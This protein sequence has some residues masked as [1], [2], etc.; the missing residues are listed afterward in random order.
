AGF[1][2]DWGKSADTFTVQGDA[3]QNGIDQPLGRED[4]T[5]EGA[6]L[7][8][9]WGRA[10]SKGSDL[11]VQVYLDHT[12]RDY[13]ASYRERRNT[14]D[15][16]VQHHF[17]IGGRNEIVWGGGYRNS[18]DEA[19]GLTPVIAFIPDTKDLRLINIFAQDQIALLADKLDL[20]LGTK[21]EHNDYT[22]WE[23]EPSARLA[24][25]PGMGQMLWAAVSRATRTPSRVD[26]ELFSPSSPPYFLAGGPNFRSELVTAY[27][28]GYR[29]QVQD[30][31]SFSISPY[32]NAYK[33]LRTVDLPPGSAA[34]VVANHMEGKTYGVEL[35]GDIKMTDSWHLRPGYAYLREHLE[36]T[37]PYALPSALYTEGNDPRHRLL[38]TSL[39][40]L[41]SNV[42]LD[43][44]L[45]H[46]SALPNPDVPAYTTMDMHIGWK[47]VL[48]LDIA[49][50]GQSLFD[51]EHREFGPVAAGAAL[52]RAG[53]V[54]VT[55]VF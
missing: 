25:K 36:L 7:L 28:L 40:S 11:Q 55:W 31:F 26:R 39:L 38:L 8:G 18:S 4:K 45:R 46:I 2:T 41:G 10:F 33:Y 19:E 16:D 34:L 20:T 47:P 29:A 9:R 53:L 42:E 12:L 24:W 49:L 23:T 35:W 21:L 51:R 30:R 48:G 17:K 3:Y 44:T 54:K 27:E 52:E 5:T 50:I 43:A 15:L 22:G 1:R 14:F 37:A 6:N 13:P 32:Y